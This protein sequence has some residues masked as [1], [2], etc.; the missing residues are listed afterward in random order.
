MF[1]CEFCEIFNNAF[2]TKH[3]RPTPPTPKFRLTPPTPFFDPREKFMDPRHPRHPRHPR[4][5]LTHATHEPVY[6]RYPRHPR[7]PRY[8][9]YLAD[10]F[11]KC[12]EMSVCAVLVLS[13]KKLLCI[14]L[15]SADR[16]GQYLKKS[17][18][19]WEIT[20]PQILP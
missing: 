18:Q 14:A 16:Y 13:D 15:M 9:R 5:N 3:L 20:I 7:Y 1:S 2:L 10:S 8:P 6:L 19:V 11:Q 12:L 4:Q 17:S